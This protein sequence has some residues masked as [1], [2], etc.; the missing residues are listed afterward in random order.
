MSTTYCLPLMAFSTWAKMAPTVAAVIAMSRMW[1]STFIVIPLRCKPR[2]LSAS[3]FSGSGEAVANGAWGSVWSDLS[4]A[5]G[6]QRPGC[7]AYLLERRIVA[8]A[9][10]DIG[11]RQATDAE[12]AAGVA[13]DLQYFPL[14]RS[15]AGRP[16]GAK[17]V[18]VVRCGRHGSGR[19]R[20][21]GADVFRRLVEE[22]CDA[23]QLA[24]S[25]TRPISLRGSQI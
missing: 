9:V 4:E 20:V 16:G 5:F 13:Q 15:E 8:Q 14:E 22:F 17:A 1:I 2:H 10:T 18:E 21:D 25:K 19:F 3:P 7:D 23:V 6:D 11:G 24:R 12:E